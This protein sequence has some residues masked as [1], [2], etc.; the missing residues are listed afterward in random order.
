[1]NITILVITVINTYFLSKKN[2]RTIS[3]LSRGIFT[4]LVVD[5]VGCFVST[6]G[7]GVRNPHCMQPGQVAFHTAS[8]DQGV[9]GISAESTNPIIREMQNARH[10]ITHKSYSEL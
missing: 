5:P 10:A 4:H 8:P 6:G 3:S 9:V 7:G 2:L 1:M